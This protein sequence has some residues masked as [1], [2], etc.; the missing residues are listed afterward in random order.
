M[1]RIMNE[2]KEWDQN[3]EEDSVEGPVD[4]R[5]LVRKKW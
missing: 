2:E 1:E 3:V 4:L 5:G